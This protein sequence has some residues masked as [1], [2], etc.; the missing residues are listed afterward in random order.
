MA[1]DTLT[2]RAQAWN[3]AYAGRADYWTSWHEAQPA[4]S[5]RLI[6]AHAPPGAGVID[7]GG[8]TSRLAEALLARGHAH[9]AVLDISEAA[10]HANRARLGARAR[11][12]RWI[13][14]D[15]TRWTP[16]TRWSVWHDRAAFH[17]LTEPDEQAAYV[18]VLLEATEPGALVLIATHAENGPDRSLR[19]PVARFAPEALARTFDAL[20]PGRL[21]LI[22]SLRHDHRALNGATLPFQYSVFRRLA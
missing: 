5:L 17:F 9:V 1:H 19:L 21:G 22:E 2:D 3:A 11:A 8:G 6:A 10:L 16:C 7:V 12:I 15:V 20:A 18:R 4:L 13:A 14:A